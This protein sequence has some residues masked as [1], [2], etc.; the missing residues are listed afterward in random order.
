[1]TDSRFVD[2][3]HWMEAQLLPADPLFEAVHA[4]AH[5]ADLPPIDVSP[6][7]GAFLGVIAGSMG[8]RHIL[9]IG[10]LAGFSTIHMARALPADGRLITIEADAKHADVAAGNFVRAGLAGRIELR[11]GAALDVLPTLSGPF[12]L[13]F[14]DA[15]KE[16]NPAYADWAAKLLRPGGLMVIDNVV[17]EGSALDDDPGNHR[18]RNIR[19]LFAAMHADS[20]FEATALQIVGAKSWDGILVA[21]R[22]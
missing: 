9:E 6:L 20:R 18:A 11:I 1:M 8:A 10:T 3:D 22:R 16:N 7:L 19:Q 17:R 21:R 15:D 12:D 2:V 13:A 14:I 5:A 4:A